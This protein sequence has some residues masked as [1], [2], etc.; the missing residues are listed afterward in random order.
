MPPTRKPASKA[1]QRAPGLSTS[2]SRIARPLLADNETNHRS[3]TRQEQLRETFATTSSSQA[4]KREQEEWNETHRG[5]LDILGD[6]DD[7]YQKLSAQVMQQRQEAQQKL[8]QLRSEHLQATATNR[9]LVTERQKALHEKQQCLGKIQ[10][11]E[12]DIAQLKQQLETAS[13]QTTEQMISQG[14]ESELE[15]AH[16]DLMGVA[17]RLWKKI[18]EQQNKRFG[19]EFPQSDVMQPPTWTNSNGQFG[20]LDPSTLPGPPMTNAFSLDTQQ[21]QTMPQINQYGALS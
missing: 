3:S 14:I 21:T 2:A 7:D 9:Q 20:A 6:A 16:G 11:L 19:L 18:Q 12:T 10:R 17:T 1:R 8:Q 13:D 5:C 4:K 15:T